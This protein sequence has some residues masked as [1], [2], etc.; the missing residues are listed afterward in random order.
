MPLS[1]NRFFEK[2][3]TLKQ[4]LYDDRSRRSEYEKEWN[5][6]IEEYGKN[7]DYLWENKILKPYL[8]SFIRTNGFGRVKFSAFILGIVI[9]IKLSK[10]ELYY[11]NSN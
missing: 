5:I 10:G 6:L 4:R 8:L 7:H 2:T 9:G 1:E 11:D 3:V